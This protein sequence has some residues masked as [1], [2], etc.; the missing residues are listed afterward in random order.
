MFSDGGPDVPLGGQRVGLRRRDLLGHAQPRR[1][2]SRAWPTPSVLNRG[3]RHGT[4][5][6]PAECDVSIRPGWFYHADARTATVKSAAQ[7]LKIYYESVGPRLQPDPERA[8]RPP[9]ADPRE[10]RQGPARSGGGSSTPPSPTT[11]PAAPRPR[12]AT[13]AATTRASPPGNVRR[14]QP[15]HL[16]GHR[17]RRDRRRAGARSGQAGHV[18]RGA[19]ARVP[20][21]G[22]AGGQLRAGLLGR[23]A[24][25]EFAAATSIGNQ[26]LLRTAGHDLQGAPA[27]HEGGGLPGDLGDRLVPPPGFTA[28]GRAAER[29][30]LGSWALGLVKK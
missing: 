29:I 1:V 8:A 15:R 22:A 10:R 13:P 11:W 17:R 5:W 16:L 18:Q 26:R 23:P 28:T 2:R 27:D 24:W 25:K 4:H 3:Q 6:L 21:A 9:R 12:P 14:R 30:G 7:L 19:R 20:A